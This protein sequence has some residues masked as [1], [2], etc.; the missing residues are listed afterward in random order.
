[1]LTLMAAAVLL[2]LL[3]FGTQNWRLPLILADPRRGVRGDR[4]G[5]LDH[6]AHDGGL[7]DL[8]PGIG[9][10]GGA[11]FGLIAVVVST[12]GAGLAFRGSSAPAATA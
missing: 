11:G 2:L 3:H 8:G 7:G 5:P 12:V 1:V 9:G 4:P 6:P 10:Y